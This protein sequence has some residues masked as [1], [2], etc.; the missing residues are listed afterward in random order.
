MIFSIIIFIFSLLVL[1][2]IHEFGH[3]MLA[4]KFGIKVEEFGFGI[5]PKVF[6]K[7]IGETIYSLNLLPIGGFVRLLGEDQVDNGKAKISPRDFRAKSV[8]QRIIVVI[9][10]VSMNLLLAWIIFYGVI[11]YQNFQIIYPTLDQGIFIGAVQKGMPAENAGIK[12]GDRVLMVEGVEVKDFDQA[13]NLIKAKK[14]TPV[15]LYISNSDGGDKKHIF[16]TPEKS[17]DTYLIGVSFSPMAFKEYKTPVDK[18]FS[19]ITYSYDLTRVTLLGFGRTISDMFGGQFNK[20][21]QSVAG[22]VGL[23]T[24]S[25]NI[26]QEGP[27]ALPLY[28][29]FVGVISL[30]LA[31]FNTLPIP[32]MDGGRLFFLIIEAV[33]KKRVRDDVEKIIHQVGFIALLALAFLIT[34]S[35]IS[36]LIH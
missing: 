3:F 25:N 17:E 5:P 18:I 29:W 26:L 20:V 4:K 9:A 33:T 2:L 12:I 28:F 32:A 31:I 10:G 21:S 14:E 15:D 36:K 1:V 19:G 11:I 34:Y 30:S 27:K 6:G 22:P 24:I 35:D 7:K 23:A 8:Y 13:R 16:V